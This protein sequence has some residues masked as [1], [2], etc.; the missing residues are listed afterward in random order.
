MNPLL[1]YN[2]TQNSQYYE[3]PKG[4]SPQ[5]YAK[6]KIPPCPEMQGPSVNE[7]I[8]VRIKYDPCATI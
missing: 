6:K 3:T 2:I 1:R 7:C 4:L 5:V 8:N